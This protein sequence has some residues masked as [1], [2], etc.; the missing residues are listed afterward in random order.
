[1]HRSAAGFHSSASI[2]ERKFAEKLTILSER[3]QGILT[4]V[5]NIKKTC[6]DSSTRP[7]C[8]SEKQLESAIKHITR[9]FPNVDTKEKSHLTAIS[10]F[11]KDIMSSLPN[12]Y[13]T[14]VDVMEFKDTTSEVIIPQTHPTCLL[15]T[16]PSPRD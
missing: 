13:F 15:Y 16:S 8:L 10:S 11:Q 1:M 12:Y 14:F 5:Y 7:S 6:A 4:R 3:G 2:S 9:K